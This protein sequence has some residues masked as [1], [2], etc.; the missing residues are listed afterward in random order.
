MAP[1]AQSKHLAASRCLSL[2]QA[3]SDLFGDEP[4]TKLWDSFV[5][6]WGEIVKCGEKSRFD[7]V[8]YAQMLAELRGRNLRVYMDNDHKTARLGWTTEEVEALAYYCAVAVMHEGKLVD[9]AK[10]AG[11]TCCDQVPVD[12]AAHPEGMAGFRCTV[13]PYGRTKLPN[14]QSLSI[15][16]DPAGVDEK[17]HQTGQVLVCVSATNGP[18]IAGA[19]PPG[20]QFSKGASFDMADEKNKESGAMDPQMTPEL[21]QL[22]A[23]LG[24]PEGVSMAA[25]IGAALAVVTA[26]GVKGEPDGDEP[27]M[28]ADEDAAAAEAKR[29]AADMDPNM[30]P[31]MKKYEDDAGMM[32]EQMGKK[33]RRAVTRA[34]ARAYACRRAVGL[35]SKELDTKAGPRAVLRGAAILKAKAPEAGELARL[36]NEFKEYKRKSDEERAQE[37]AARAKTEAHTWEVSVK[38]LLNAAGPTNARIFDKVG[39]EELKCRGGDGRLSGD[40]A[41]ALFETAAKY[42]MSPA[43]VEQMIPAH[44]FSFTADGSPKGSKGGGAS[45]GA[46]FP[47]S[48]ADSTENMIGGD[49]SAKIREFQS[50]Y[51]KDSGGK[52]IITRVAGAILSPMLAAGNYDYAR[53]KEQADRLGPDAFL[54]GK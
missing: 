50:Q 28:E 23:V 27:M 54:G 51:A 1:R 25:I 46:D 6:V 31:G 16:F 32:P 7:E 48:G 3:P 12:P 52:R 18:H 19:G 47:R 37:A 36:A 2:A 22:A 38:K 20:G 21:Q 33:F 49:H 17:G 41:K 43:E 24:L 5:P 4:K 30:A 13:T 53:A 15:Q 8:T 14:Y 45:S 26:A 10:L 40:K 29:M 11:H 39:E 9:L 35:L 44:G 34:I 42:K